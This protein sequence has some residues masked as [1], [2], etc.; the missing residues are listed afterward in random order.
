MY[1]AARMCFSNDD[2]DMDYR[3]NPTSIDIVEQLNKKE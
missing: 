2:D 3:Y 1:G